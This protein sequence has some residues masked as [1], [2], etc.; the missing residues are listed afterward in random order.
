MVDQ[1]WGLDLA[2]YSTGKSALALAKRE[3]AKSVLIKIFTNHPFMKK[4]EGR[5]QIASQINDER[6]CINRC[7]PIYIDMPIDLQ[8]LPKIKNA[9]FS[10]QLTKR[11][12][13]VAYSAM[14]PFADRIG[15]PVARLQAVLGEEL[16]GLG[17]DYFETYPNMSL[18][19]WFGQAP[20]SYKSSSKT[21]DW[22][23]DHW[24]GETG[25]ATLLNQ[26]GFVGAKD[27]KLNDDHFD[28][29]ICALVGLVGE[30]HLLLDDKLDA[31]IQKQMFQTKKFRKV[32]Q[33]ALKAI[34][35]AA[36]KGYR[37][38]SKKL[39]GWSIKVQLT[40][41]APHDETAS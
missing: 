19:K 5:H 18:H 11:A 12:I 33:D 16:L 39:E 37:I 22:E 15:S 35:L 17:N 26:C 32:D 4:I 38:I 29:C 28:A 23:D 40:D 24:V 14:P 2:G 21:A 41:D 36:P 7:S 25:L 20:P 34:N 30:D 9:T 3:S 13:D 27:L 8:N 1:S 6:R 31:D 10:W